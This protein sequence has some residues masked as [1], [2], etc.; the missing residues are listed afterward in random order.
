MAYKREIQAECSGSATLKRQSLE[1]EQ[2]KAAGIY[3]RVLEKRKIWREIAPKINCMS[4]IVLFSKP[5]CSISFFCGFSKGYDIHAW[6]I[7]DIG[8]K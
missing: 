5:L 3:N 2:A 8:Q 1:F 7:L 6:L 4:S